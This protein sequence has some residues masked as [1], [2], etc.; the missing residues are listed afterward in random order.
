MLNDE[1]YYTTWVTTTVKI[2]LFQTFFVP[3]PPLNLPARL[4]ENTCFFFDGMYR[5]TN[6]QYG[7]NIVEK[8]TPEK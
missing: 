1:I 4:T 5:C 6:R 8:K 7:K 3:K 2:A